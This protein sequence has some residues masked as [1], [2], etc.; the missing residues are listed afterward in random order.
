MCG[1]A[2]IVLSPQ[3]HLD[4]QVLLAMRDVQSHRGPDQA[5]IYLGRGAGLGHRR[6]SI[7]DLSH[8]QQPMV[9]E[10]AGLAL[11]YNG[12]LYNFKSLRAE[13]EALGTV[14]VSHGDTEVLLRAWQHWGEAC[15]PRLVG[16]FAFAV[17]DMRAADLSGS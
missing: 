15:L 11:I 5:G 10:A 8:G 4:E 13:L 1:L 2:G 7:I 14:F 3:G 6:L 17:W 9:D 12:E 16:M